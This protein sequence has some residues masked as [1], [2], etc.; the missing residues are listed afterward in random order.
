MRNECL[1]LI[2]AEIPKGQYHKPLFE[3]N[4]HIVIEVVDGR[5]VETRLPKEQAQR[6]F[7]K[8]RSAGGEATIREDKNEK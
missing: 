6:L 3:Q 2:G 5:V 4:I 1:R 8:I 7:R